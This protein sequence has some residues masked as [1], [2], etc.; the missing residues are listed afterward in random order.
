MKHNTHM[1]KVANQ[2]LWI[3]LLIIF[4]M[5][6]VTACSFTQSTELNDPPSISDSE[7]QE[8]VSTSDSN[9]SDAGSDDSPSGFFTMDDGVAMEAYKAVV[10][11]D[12]TF[13]DTGTGKDL[14]ITH[15]C[16]VFNPEISWVSI[17]FT[18]IDLDGDGIRE[19]I[20]MLDSNARYGYEILH[21]QDGTIYGYYVV[22]RGFEEL[23]TDSTYQGSSSAF[24]GNIAKIKSFS[25]NGFTAQIMVQYDY[26]TYDY[27]DENELHTYFMINGKKSSSAQIESLLDQQSAKESVKWYDV[28]EKSIEDFL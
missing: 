6:S 18:I 21:Y 24:S 9:H 20:L 8:P 4:M 7:L 14:N 25:E 22:P 11:G 23:K 3:A 2:L 17:Y 5:I 27:L 28:A 26:H 10:C 19:V 1:V 15:I 12:T 16:E 13:R